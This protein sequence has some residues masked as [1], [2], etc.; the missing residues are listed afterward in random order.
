MSYLPGFEAEHRDPG[1]SQ[2]YTPPVLAERIWR[3]SRAPMVRR[4]LEPS[5]GIGNLLAPIV[6]DGVHV[7]ACETDPE[8]A[9]VLLGRFHRVSLSVENFLNV[10]PFPEPFD[11]VVMNPPYENGQDV[12]HIEHAIGFAP[13]VVALVLHSILFSQRRRPFWTERVQIRRGARLSERPKFGPK[14]GERDFVVV[15]LTRRIGK[16][17]ADTEQW[18]WW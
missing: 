1:L 13:R 5:A 12:E 17:S 2:W 7:H 3:W 15:E 8:K 18:E 10:E 9:N 6:A 11:L 4:V 16:S 14:G